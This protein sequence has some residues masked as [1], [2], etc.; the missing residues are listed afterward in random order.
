MGGVMSKKRAV[1][2]RSRRS[3]SLLRCLGV[4]AVSVLPIAGFGVST[5]AS[6]ADQIPGRE[7]VLCGLAM[8]SGYSV[9]CARGRTLR[10]DVDRNP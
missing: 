7:S 9:V 2:S 3:V 6:R 5:Q 8:T 10:I 1:H 4:V